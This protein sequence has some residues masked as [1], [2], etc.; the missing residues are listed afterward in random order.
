MKTKKISCVIL[1]LILALT[2]MGANI[3][4]ALANTY[5]VTNST[6]IAQMLSAIDKQSFSG[7]GTD[8]AKA[9]KVISHFIS[10]SKWK[11][12]GEH[13]PYPNAGYG[14]VGTVNDGAYS[15]TMNRV[16]AGCYAYA[17]YIYGAVYGTLDMVRVGDQ[18]HNSE[19][20]K[21]LLQEKGQAGAHLRIDGRHSLAFISATDAGF[22]ALEYGGDNSA[23]TGGP[24]KLSYWTYEKFIST[25]GSRDIW[26]YRITALGGNNV[27][28]SASITIPPNKPSGLTV[29]KASSTTARISWN[30]ASGATYIAEYRSPNTNNAWVKDTEYKGGTS[31]IATRLG[32]HTYGFRVRSVNSA[33]MS[34]WTEIEYVNS[35]V[36]GAVTGVLIGIENL[37]PSMPSGLRAS[38]SNNTTAE[39][40]WNEVSGATSYEAEYK[41]PNTN[42]AW[43]KD[44]E[45]RDSKALSYTVTQ[46]GSHNYGFRI[47]A[48]N[49]AGVSPWAEITYN[50]SNNSNAT[51]DKTYTIKYDA[52]GGNGA[53]SSQTKTEGVPLTINSTKPTRSGYN[54]IGWGE[55][56]NADFYSTYASGDTYN[57]DADVTLYAMWH[58]TVATTD[59]ACYIN[60]DANGGI[61][62]P[63]NHVEVKD[64]N[65]VVTFNL[66][67]T[68]PLRHGY[69]FIGW[70]YENNTSYGLDMP[71]Q[72]ITFDTGV[73]NRNSSLTYYAQWIADISSS[74]NVTPPKTPSWLKYSRGNSNTTVSWE[75]VQGVLWYELQFIDSSNV[76][77]TPREF[78]NNTMTSFSIRSFGNAYEIRDKDGFPHYAYPVRVRAV[79][80]AGASGWIETIYFQNGRAGGSD[81]TETKFY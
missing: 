75:N 68:E 27:N 43:K 47:R 20:L 73:T 33:G 6:E 72:N 24:I 11:P 70:R 3:E 35:G 71:N 38:K 19:T 4:S 40:S 14:Y 55:T 1:S 37:K 8:A 48:V 44:T 50:H 56:P 45:Y 17:D 13:F 74:N 30:A 9:K 26:L 66:S 10:N 60:Y 7:S 5:N 12:N 81:W 34:D 79:N 18:K 15:I 65:G 57:K 63:S 2:M 51:V 76:W 42:G 77:F 69:T 58:M 41:S 52:N 80:S 21:T 31:Y 54:F 28:S 78:T 16:C 29:S 49:A 53:P 22:Y 59:Y 61:G 32:S 23:G 67:R 25:Y 46:L 62:A 36:L 64:A 39:I